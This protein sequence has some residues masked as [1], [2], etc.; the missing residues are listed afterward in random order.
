MPFLPFF[1]QFQRSPNN[2]HVRM[3][4][5]PPTNRRTLC[6]SMLRQEKGISEG[7]VMQDIASASIPILNNTY[8][9]ANRQNAIINRLNNEIKN[10]DGELQTSKLEQQSYQIQL[11]ILFIVGIIIIYI[12]IKAFL[13]KGLRFEIIGCGLGPF[14]TKFS[15]RLASKIIA[16]ANIITHNKPSFIHL[17]LRR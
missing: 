2:R 17:I 6:Q 11:V 10:I 7:S 15:K 16:S 14:K 5:G 4:N 12:T 8:K 9:R 13:S 3:A 1:L